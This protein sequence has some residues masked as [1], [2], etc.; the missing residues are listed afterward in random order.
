MFGVFDLEMAYN[1]ILGRPTITKFIVATHY[2]Y[3]CMKISGPEGII[4]IRGCTKA[5]LYCDKQSLDMATQHQPDK[6]LKNSRPKAV[7]KSHSEV[8]TVPSDPTE[9]SKTIQIGSKL[10]PK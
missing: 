7:M 8:K 4:T 5:G 1:V 3:Q 9:P 10:D 2:T 6:E